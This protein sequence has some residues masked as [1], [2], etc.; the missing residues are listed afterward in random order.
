MGGNEKMPESKLE[1]S[2]K[3]YHDNKEKWTVP[4]GYKDTDHHTM[5]PIAKTLSSMGMRCLFGKYGYCERKDRGE[6]YECKR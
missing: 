3:Y 4:G 6:Y 2:R 1:Y 5:C